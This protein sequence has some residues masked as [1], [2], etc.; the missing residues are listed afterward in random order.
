MNHPIAN[1]LRNGP[2]SYSLVANHI[3]STPSVIESGPTMYITSNGN[4]AT[5]SSSN[6]GSNIKKKTEETKEKATTSQINSM[7]TM[8]LLIIFKKKV[9][10]F[11]IR[12]YQLM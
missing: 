2:A 10:V 4:S 12:L 9:F 3:P 11:L 5:S 7:K 8:V 1:L 6:G